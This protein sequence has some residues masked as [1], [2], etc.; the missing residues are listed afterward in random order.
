MK[1]LTEEKFEQYQKHTDAQFKTT[2]GRL[3]V[4]EFEL[5]EL[6][7]EFKQMFSVVEEK[8]EKIIRMLD[9]DTHWKSETD[10]EVASAH[11]R[12]DRVEGHLGLSV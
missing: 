11:A 10:A 5:K 9:K 2:D 7:K 8:F 12:L 6:R 3:S 4:V 1:Y